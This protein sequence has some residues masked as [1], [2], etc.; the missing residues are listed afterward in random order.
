MRLDPLRRGTYGTLVA[1]LLAATAGC[2]RE[3]PRGNLEGKVS[4]AGVPLTTGTVTLFG[5][6]GKA[7]SVAQI[8]KDGAYGFGQTPAGKF[9]LGVDSP[10]ARG[11]PGGG[12]ANPSPDFEARAEAALAKKRARQEVRPDPAEVQGPR[13]VRAGRGGQTRHDQVRHRPREVTPPARRQPRRAGFF[14]NVTST[15]CWRSLAAGV[16]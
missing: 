2:S 11:A 15:C 10:P 3:D 6:D 13:Q 14:V 12:Q 8:R 1:L 7:L 9:A 16:I 5:P 4:L